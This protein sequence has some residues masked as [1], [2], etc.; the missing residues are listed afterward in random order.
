MTDETM[1]PGGE[2]SNNV[3]GNKDFEIQLL[4]EFTGASAE[5]IKQAIEVVGYDWNKINE[6]LRNLGPAGFGESI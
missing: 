4:K 3:A 6:Y 5:E 1:I 2:D